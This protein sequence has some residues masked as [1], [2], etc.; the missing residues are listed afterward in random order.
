MDT[1]ELIQQLS[2]DLKPVKVLAAPPVRALQLSI[3]ALVLVM[4]VLEALGGPRSDWNAAL[5]R[6]GFVFET[7]I[8]FLAGLLAASAAFTLS[9]PDTRMRRP[10]TLLLAAATI[11]WLG[12]CLVAAISLTAQDIRHEVSEI[13]SSAACVKALLFMTIAPLLVSF[14]MT[15]CA[16]PVWRGWAGYALTLSVASFGAFGMRFFCPSDAPAHLFLW[17]FLPVV[18]LSLL[19]AG[20][21]CI[22]L[23]MRGPVRG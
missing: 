18:V 14:W 15:L 6:A 22:V 8:I 20:L 12:I 2:R 11:I 1:N 4:A 7:G 17:H 9:I 5:Q 23:R 16:A 3:V 21:G 13:P 19:G 10:V